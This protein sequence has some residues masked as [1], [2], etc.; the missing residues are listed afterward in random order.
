MF[1]NFEYDIMTVISSIF[2][3]YLPIGDMATKL[4][5]SNALSRIMSKLVVGM[6]SMVSHFRRILNFFWKENYI[7]IK[8]DN[9][10]YEKIIDYLY[11]KYFEM[12][13]GCRLESD[14]GKNKMV[15]DKLNTKSIVEE[16]VRRNIVSI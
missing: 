10:A 13:S 1:D 15:I 2:I 9:P 5:V 6:F 16:F 14:F 12:I 7:I 3:L 8:K 11:S 4:A